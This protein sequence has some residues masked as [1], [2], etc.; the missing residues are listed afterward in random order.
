[1]KSSR[2]YKAAREY[3]GLSKEDVCAVLSWE[4]EDLDAIESGTEPSLEM[5]GMLYK[6]YG[7][8]DKKSYEAPHFPDI[9]GLS[10]H[11]RRE[12]VKMFLFGEEVKAQIY[13]NE[14]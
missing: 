9:E 3:L 14:E 10:E 4:M 6:L 1:M 11:D 2:I 12:V 13:K 8:S 7:L 5:Q